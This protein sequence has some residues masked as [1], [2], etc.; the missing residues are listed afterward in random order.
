M[1][2][3]DGKDFTADDVVFTYDILTKDKTLSASVTSNF[4]DISS[5][6]ALDDHT[7]VIKLSKY[8]AAMLDYFT[9]GILPKHLLK[10][11]RYQHR[12]F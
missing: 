5:V 9:M 6:K 1:K 8:N 3:H 10:G 7:V 11:G 12:F 4:E 2:W